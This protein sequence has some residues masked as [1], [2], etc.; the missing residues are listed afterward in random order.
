MPRSATKYECLRQCRATLD[1]GLGVILDPQTAVNA[2]NP[3]W[4]LKEGTNA[5]DEIVY[6]TGLPAKSGV[7]GGLIAVSPGKL[8]VAVLS[9]RLDDAGNSVRAQRAI[10]RH[11]KNALGGNP[12]APTAR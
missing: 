2:F 5:D 4:N 3:L 8:G 10:R 11:F 1:R 6:Q 12:L 9:P 7:G